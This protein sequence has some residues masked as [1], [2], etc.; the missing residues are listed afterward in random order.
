[1][2]VR[3][4]GKQ[5]D[6]VS[7]LLSQTKNVGYYGGLTFG[8]GYCLVII[9]AIA[10][11][12]EL[13]LRGRSLLSS[14]Y[15]PSVVSSIPPWVIAF[16]ISLFVSV[17]LAIVFGLSVVK[18]S[19]SVRDLG[20]KIDAISSSVSTLSFMLIFLWISMTILSFGI[21][22]SLFS[23]ISGIVGSVLLFVGFK[24][25]RKETSESKLM[26]A[27]LMLISVALTYFVALR[28][29]GLSLIGAGPLFS[30]FTLE[31]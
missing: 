18:N 19:K 2:S 31:F 10:V 25:Y 21:R 9:G 7:R 22:L 24:A 28:G 1:M 17:I 30:E 29:S 20:P 26:G 6:S 23:P 3:L 14:Y 11:V 5:D 4:M 15:T 13:V 8:I 27:I 16:L 12:A